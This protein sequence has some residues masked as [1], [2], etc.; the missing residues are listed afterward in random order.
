MSSRICHLK[1]S[2]FVRFFFLTVSLFVKLSII[3]LLAK[4]Q[5]YSMSV[6]AENSLVMYFKQDKAY[7]IFRR[8]T[9]PRANYFLRKQ[10]IFMVKS[11]EYYYIPPLS[12]T[13][14][15]SLPSPPNFYRNDSHHSSSVSMSISAHNRLS[16]PRYVTISRRTRKNDLDTHNFEVSQQI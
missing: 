10:F 8:T 4:S 1:P 2:F 6:W 14:N 16:D 9:Q 5:L 7:F 15:T 11:A 3:F 13:V 12:L